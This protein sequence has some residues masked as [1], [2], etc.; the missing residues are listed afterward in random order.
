MLSVYKTKAKW[1]GLAGRSLKCFLDDDFL[2]LTYLIMPS[3]TNIGFAVCGRQL[4]E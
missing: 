4:A 2:F 3:V 1:T